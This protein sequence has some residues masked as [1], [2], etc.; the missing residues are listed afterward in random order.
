MKCL[1][2]NDLSYKSGRKDIYGLAGQ[3]RKVFHSLGFS[4]ISVNTKYRVNPCEILRIYLNHSSR[5]KVDLEA[6]NCKNQIVYKT[7]LF[8]GYKK[9]RKNID[10]IE[11]LA[12]KSFYNINR[13]EDYFFLKK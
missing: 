8:L 13:S 11:Y 4:L 1:F 9:I 5:S 7:N 10:K 12:L 3:T 6:R 2:F